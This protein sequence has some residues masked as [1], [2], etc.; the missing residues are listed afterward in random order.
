VTIIYRIPLIKQKTIR[1]SLVDF[2]SWQQYLKLRHRALA[3]RY[4][5]LH[6]DR[7]IAGDRMPIRANN[8][9]IDELLRNFMDVSYRIQICM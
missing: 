1:A 9:E 6:F 3:Q 5:R 8:G 2:D 7:I 4:L